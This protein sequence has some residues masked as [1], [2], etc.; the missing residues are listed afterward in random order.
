M[1]RQI[2]L[3]KGVQ[4]SVVFGIKDIDRSNVTAGHVWSEQVREL[5]TFL[6]QTSAD[7]EDPDFGLWIPGSEA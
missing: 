2:H 7:P 1:P 5:V 4:V 3:E 6:T